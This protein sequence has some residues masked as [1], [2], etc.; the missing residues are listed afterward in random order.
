MGRE[1]VIAWAGRHRR[2]EWERLLSRYRG[3]IERSCGFRE[4]TV[5]VRA[6]ATDQERRRAEGEALL[7]ALPDPCWTIAVTRTGKD[8]DSVGFA[9]RLEE[10]KETWPHPVAFLVGS[11]LGLDTGIVEGAR[12]R[13]SLG[14]MTLPHELAR[15][16]LYEQI[17]RALSIAAGIKYHRHPL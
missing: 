12:E 14:P 7:R 16:V 17:Y 9:R 8:L 2:D 13:L 5:K 15:L 10:L 1:I 11:D 6:E 4:I 3:R